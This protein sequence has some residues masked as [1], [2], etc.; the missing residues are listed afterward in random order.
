MTATSMI[1]QKNSLK[2]VTKLGSKHC[3]IFSFRYK[4]ISPKLCLIVTS[5]MRISHRF[6]ILRNLKQCSMQHRETFITLVLPFGCQPTGPGSTPNNLSKL[7][8]SIMAAWCHW[9]TNSTLTLLWNAYC[10]K[11][12]QMIFNQPTV[13][14]WGM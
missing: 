7:Q 8:I 11:K 9:M 1:Q 4:Y 12:I 13:Q 14:T 6:Q 3:K 2:C 5:S 10:S